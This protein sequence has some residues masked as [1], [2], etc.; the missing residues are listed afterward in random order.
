MHLREA[1]HPRKPEL[2]SVDQFESSATSEPPYAFTDHDM[3]PSRC[4][5][6]PDLVD[7]LK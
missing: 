5:V 2:A 4:M 7:T 1:H 6:C 3:S